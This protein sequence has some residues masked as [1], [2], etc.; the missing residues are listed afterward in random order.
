[1]TSFISV[2]FFK[3]TLIS[4]S[5]DKTFEIRERRINQPSFTH[6]VHHLELRGYRLSGGRDQMDE[7]IQ[8]LFRQA[9][10]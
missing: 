2:D 3:I 4:K 5:D 7:R 10:I 8:V 6:I 9:L 1:M